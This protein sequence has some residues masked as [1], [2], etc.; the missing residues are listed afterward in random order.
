MKTI[1]AYLI[2]IIISIGMIFIMP[3]LVEM[4]IWYMKKVLFVNSALIGSLGGVLY[5]LRAVY[6]NKSVHKRWDEDWI[7][8]YYLRPLTSLL[9]GLV[10]SIFLKAGLLTL[11]AVEGGSTFG[12]LAVAFIAGYNV[13]NF[14]KKIEDVAKTVW[15][16][17]K[18][19]V[20][21]DKD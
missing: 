3:E 14:L 4:P 11:D 1:I 10:S 13:D 15:G 6:L 16:I 20:G 9:S 21:N 7:V 19:R 2:F 5:C 8:W 12:Y 18:S 17:D